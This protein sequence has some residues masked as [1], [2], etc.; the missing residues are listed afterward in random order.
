MFQ[1]TFTCDVRTPMTPNSDFPEYLEYNNTNNIRFELTSDIPWN[2]FNPR[3]NVQGKRTSFMNEGMFTSVIQ[4]INGPTDKIE[5]DLICSTISYQCNT[6][7]IS[8][9]V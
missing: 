7:T 6:Y 2:C 1:P 9:K 8:K 5:I 4:D 3:L